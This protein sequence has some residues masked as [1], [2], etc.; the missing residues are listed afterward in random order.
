MTKKKVKISKTVLR[1]AMKSGGQAFYNAERGYFTNKYIML[2]MDKYGGVGKDVQYEVM[3]AAGH[4]P[5]ETNLESRKVDIILDK[6]S[7]LNKLEDTGLYS[8]NEATGSMMKILYNPKKDEYHY[9]ALLYWDAFNHI[10]DPI[11]ESSG[12]FSP[13]FISDQSGGL[14][15]LILPIRIQ[16]DSRYLKH[17]E[18]HNE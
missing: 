14:W 13:V 9:I 4:E 1:K 7:G 5:F 10:E 6:I 17:K 11:L 8:I 3:R 2:N 15:G 12:P 16:R 18:V